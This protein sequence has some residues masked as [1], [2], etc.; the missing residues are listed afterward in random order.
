MQRGER[1]YQT[2]YQATLNPEYIVQLAG[3]LEKAGQFSKDLS[4]REK[5]G[6]IYKFMTNQLTQLK[7]QL[8]MYKTLPDCSELQGGKSQ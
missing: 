7:R 3:E 4:Q 6:I 1:L 5:N 8:D 2:T